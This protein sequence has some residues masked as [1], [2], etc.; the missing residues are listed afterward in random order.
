VDIAFITLAVVVSALSTGCAVRAVRLYDGPKLPDERVAIL[1][2]RGGAY[3]VQINDKAVEPGTGRAE[4]LPG[5]SRIVYWG[6]FGG[7]VMLG[8]PIRRVGPLTAV[9][10]LEAGRTYVVNAERRGSWDR[11]SLYLWIED[12]ASARVLH[13]ARPPW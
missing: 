4:L 5:Q 13:G 3:V 9:L 12:V 6:E 10:T 7:S 11:P 8:P 2:S 1:E